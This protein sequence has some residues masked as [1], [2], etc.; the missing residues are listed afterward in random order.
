[1][2]QAAPE[3]YAML[4]PVVEGLGY[5]LAG[6]ESQSG[7]RRGARGLVRIYIDRPEGISVDDCQRVSE[8]VSGVLDVADPIDARYTLE[9]SSPGLD[10]PLFALEHFARHVGQE[11]RVQLEVPIEGRRR[12]RAIIE[13]VEGSQV[14]LREGERVHALGLDQIAQARVIPE[15]EL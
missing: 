4:R 8:Q 15:Y 10:R 12:F 9:V 7:G 6:I 3:L 13:A 14:R 11:V 5:E 1:M 2:R